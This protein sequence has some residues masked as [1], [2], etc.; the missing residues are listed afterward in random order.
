MPLRAPPGNGAVLFQKGWEKS[1]AIN[2]ERG[3]RTAA[4]RDIAELKAALAV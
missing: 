3:S 4:I 2:T 1:L